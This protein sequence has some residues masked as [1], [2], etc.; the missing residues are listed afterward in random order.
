MDPAQRFST[1]GAF[2]DALAGLRPATA[3]ITQRGPRYAAKPAPPPKPAE[4][5]PPPKPGE[6]PPEEKK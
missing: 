5:K 1:V 3:G 4:K 2:V 6:T